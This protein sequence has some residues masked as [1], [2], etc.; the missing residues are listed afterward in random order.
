MNSTSCLRQVEISLID[1]D[2]EIFTSDM[3]SY[4]LSSYGVSKKKLPAVE[5]RVL[6]VQ[7]QEWARV[8]AIDSREC[9]GPICESSV[10]SCR[11]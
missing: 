10:Y 8:S 5:V 3:R 7:V 6:F 2:P 9:V 1:Q 11:A 4:L